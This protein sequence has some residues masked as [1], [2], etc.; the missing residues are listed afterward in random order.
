MGNQVPQIAEDGITAAAV[1]DFER[2]VHASC[3]IWNDR[4]LYSQYNSDG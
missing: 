4:L 1:G 2:G 3:P